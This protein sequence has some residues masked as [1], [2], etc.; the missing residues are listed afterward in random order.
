METELIVQVLTIGGPVAL[1]ALMVICVNYKMYMRW[2]DQVDESYAS[3]QKAYADVQKAMGE[4]TEAL[5]HI[6]GRK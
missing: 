6:N 2:M 4:V 3:V 1:I 5:R